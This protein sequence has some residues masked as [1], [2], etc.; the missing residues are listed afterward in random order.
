MQ[1][2]KTFQNFLTR[3]FKLTLPLQKIKPTS[4]QPAFLCGTAKTHKFSNTDEINKDNLKL[5]PMVNTIVM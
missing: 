1:D 2:L 3:N 4:K 5:R